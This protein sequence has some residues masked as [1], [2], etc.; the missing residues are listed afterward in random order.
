MQVKAAVI[1]RDSI[2][3][4]GH[5]RLAQGRTVTRMAQRRAHHIFGARKAVLALL[6]IAR[7][8]EHQ[9]L[10]AGLDI[11]ILLPARLGGTDGLEPQLGRKVHHVDRCVAGQVRQV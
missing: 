1:G 3:L 4:A 10:R 6:Q 11:D 9:I 7:I 5:K 2:D 8:V